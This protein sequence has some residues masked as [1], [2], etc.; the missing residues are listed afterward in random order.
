MFHSELWPRA[1]S[2]LCIQNVPAPRRDPS[3]AH[4]VSLQPG[5][6]LPSQM[7]DRS[8]TSILTKKPRTHQEN[9]RL[10]TLSFLQKRSYALSRPW[11]ALHIVAYAGVIPP[12]ETHLV[13]MTERPG[14]IRMP[15]LIPIIYIPA[16]MI[17]EV[18]SSTFKSILKALP[19]RIPELLRRCIPSPAR[20]ALILARTRARWRTLRRPVLRLRHACSS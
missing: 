12:L 2:G 20:T 5:A 10:R 19:R 18:L 16:A 11:S 17:L 4:A 1:F 6:D 15:E 13:V 9:A 3:P 8:S 7:P 14:N